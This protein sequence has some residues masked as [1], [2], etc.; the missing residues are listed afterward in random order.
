MSLSA[1]KAIGAVLILSS[2]LIAGIMAYMLNELGE[3]A[4]ESC[5]CGED[6]CEMKQFDIPAVFYVGA[7]ATLLVFVSGLLLALRKDQERPDE[8]RKNWM[9]TA[10][11]LDSDEKSLYLMVAERDGAMFQSEL[12]EKTGHTKVRVT[13]MLDKLEAKGLIERRRRGLTNIIVLKDH[14]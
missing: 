7:G 5:D 12:V 3:K 14:K 6:F 8:R 2:L 11:D 13:R 9:Q 4:N 1:N 10:R